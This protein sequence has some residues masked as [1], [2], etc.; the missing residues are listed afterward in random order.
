L[1]HNKKVHILLDKKNS[2]KLPLS[3]IQLLGLGLNFCLKKP[4][5]TNK[6][7]ATIKYF[8]KDIRQEYTFHH[9]PE[10]KG[11]YTANELLARLKFLLLKLQ[12]IILNPPNC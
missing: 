3:S 2:K 9:V 4:K 10:G 5:P 1:H 6:I 7:K 11:D 12:V 8:K